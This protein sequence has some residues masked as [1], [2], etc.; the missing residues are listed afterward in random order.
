MSPAELPDP[1]RD[2]RERLVAL[3]RG[4]GSCGVAFSGGLDSTVLAKAAVVALGDRAVALTAASPSMPSGE[5]DA[6]AAVARRIGIRHE[7]LETDEL[8]DPDYRANTPERCYFCKSR[9]LREIRAAAARLGLAAVVDGTNADDLAEDR[10]GHRAAQ[11]QDVRSPLAECGLTKDNLRALAAAWGLPV[12][13]KPASPCLSSRIA[14]GEEITAP[15]LAMIDEAEAFLRRYG[16]RPL[17]VRYHRGDLA[18]IEVPSDALARL[19]DETFRREV[20]SVL[21]SLGFCYVSLDLEGFRSGSLNEGLWPSAA[22][23]GSDGDQQQEHG[24]KDAGADDGP[25]PRGQV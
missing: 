17:R 21:K 1:L 23:S 4:L 15:R 6:A 18:R 12:W 16:F 7:V 2:P 25:N 5:L 19:A 24:Q 14:F 20:V 11:E 3:L 10:P 22:R 8:S 9:I 13:D